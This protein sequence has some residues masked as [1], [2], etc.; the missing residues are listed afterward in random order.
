MAEHARQ[1]AHPGGLRPGGAADRPAPRAGAGGARPPGAAGGHA[2]TAGISTD[3]GFWG[4][5]E[6]AAERAGERVWRLPIY[7][8]YRVLLRSQI[9]DLRN[10]DYGEAGSIT[11][12]MFIG[13]VARGRARGP[14]PHPGR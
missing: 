14:L 7:P 6:Q 9:A 2:A 11:G 10:A 3:D 1:R 13:E 4:L 8:D 5:V 12:G